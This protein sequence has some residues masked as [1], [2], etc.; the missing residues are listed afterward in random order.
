MITAT[1]PLAV[2]ATILADLSRDALRDRL[3][4]LL[5]HST[6]LLAI[7]GSALLFFV[8]L[9]SAFINSPSRAV[10]TARRRPN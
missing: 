8:V 2:Y 3:S 4:R 6:A 9:A 10:S 5:R 7:V 1:I